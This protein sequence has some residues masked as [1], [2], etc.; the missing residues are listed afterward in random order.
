MISLLEMSG[1]KTCE[2]EVDNNPATS[3]CVDCDFYLCK[4]CTAVHK[5]QRATKGHIMIP[6]ADLKK[7]GSQVEQKR[8]CSA[9]PKDEV[10]VYCRT[11]EEVICRDCT[12][13]T[14]KQHDYTLIKDVREELAKKL[15]EQVAGVETKENDICDVVDCCYKTAQEEKKKVAIHEDKINAMIDKGV[16]KTEAQIADLQ[17][18]IVKLQQQKTTL[19]KNISDAS[20]AYLKQL[21]GQKRNL[22]FDREGLAGAVSFTEQLLSSASNTDVAILTKQVSTQLQNLNKF[23]VPETTSVKSSEW[24]LEIS[25]ENLL[26]GQVINVPLSML[27]DLISVTEMPNPALTG[28][29]TFKV[30]VKKVPTA[31]KMD[32]QVKATTNTGANCPVKI[33]QAG[34]HSWTVSYFIALPC[35]K[36][37]QVVVTVNDVQP[38]KSPYKIHCL[39]KL[40]DGTRVKKKGQKEKGTVIVEKVPS[41]GADPTTSVKVRWDGDNYF[42]TQEQPSDLRIIPD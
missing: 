24:S 28:K 27:V 41:F 13:V 30:A 1:N 5:K 12:I 42:T 7:G 18:H 39:N 9:H 6:L 16:E 15:K 10:K 3:K 25:E 31:A 40:A 4:D 34:R 21:S 23:Q 14:H 8:Y 17:Q 20:S 32:L 37:V 22:Q 35:P 26:Q 38:T 33:E 2:N 19:L 29:N 36:Q 11:C